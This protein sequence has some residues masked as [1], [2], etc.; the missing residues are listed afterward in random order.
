MIKYVIILLFISL[1]FLSSIFT[2]H[3][4]L[5]PINQLVYELGSPGTS[6]QDRQKVEERLKQLPSDEVLPI[7][8]FEVAEGMPDGP[9]WSSAGPDH[10][11]EKMPHLNGKL[12]TR[13]SESGNTIF[14]AHLLK[15][16]ESC[17]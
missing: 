8:L 12:T 13:Y 3:G 11:K 14:R 5:E 4:G 15:L 9:I 17:S 16:W 6:W 10:D 2:G 1:F 7:L